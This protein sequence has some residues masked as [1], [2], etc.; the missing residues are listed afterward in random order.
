MSRK[1]YKAKEGEV[2]DGVCKGIADYFD[3]DPV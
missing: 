3:I 2:L 1:L